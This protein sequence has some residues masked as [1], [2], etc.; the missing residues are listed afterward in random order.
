MSPRRR[1]HVL[2]IVAA[3]GGLLLFAWAARRAGISE[4]LEG[5]RRIGWRLLP[6]L[7]LGGLRFVV[8]AE[9]WRL[10]APAGRRLPF[11]Q[12]FTSFLAGDAMGNLTPLGMLASEPTKVLLTRHH[13]ATRDSVSSLAIDNVIYAG[14]VLAMIV[15]AGGVML[16]TVAMPERWREGGALA[17][18]LLVVVTLI[19]AR[20]ARRR[21]IIGRFGPPAWRAR[22][23]AIRASVGEF[24]AGHPF[25]LWR[26][27]AL[28]MAFHA[29]AVIEAYLALGW[30]LGSARPTFREAL[31]FEALNRVITVAFKFVP[32]RIG[33]DEASSGAL[34]PLLAMNPVVGVSLA[35]VRKVRNLFWAAVGV[36][37]I[38][39]HHARAE[40]AT[41]RPGSAPAHRT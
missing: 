16:A 14:S 41:D 3:L 35:V 28:D 30:L 27:F 37:L 1:Q 20:I 11:H 24:T 8:R 32:F 6:I 15:G 31:L 19:V 33:V 10:C 5:I 4:I 34:A 22:V 7:A 18:A 40:P 39:V 26:V 21:T 13:L 25:R 38:A 17:L 36:G 9:A 23:A 12:A 29:L 2:T